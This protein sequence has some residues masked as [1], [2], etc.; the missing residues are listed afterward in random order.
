MEIW[1]KLPYCIFGKFKIL[2]FS[3]ITRLIYPK[4]HPNQE[5]DYCLIAPNQKALFIETNIFQKR[6]VTNQRAGNYKTAGNYKITPLTVQ[7]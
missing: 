1:D 6:E 4:N 3:K 7:C 2:K 5:C